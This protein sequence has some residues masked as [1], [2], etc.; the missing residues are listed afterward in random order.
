MKIQFAFILAIFL[1]LANVHQLQSCRIMKVD[2][3]KWSMVLQ[4]SL[5]RAP[6]PPS[7]KDGGT[8]IPVPLGERAFAGK[9]MAPPADAYPD[10]LLIPSGVALNTN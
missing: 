4:Q 9:F 1:V 5:Q 6:V 7:G 8:T 3:Q 10:H 2:Q